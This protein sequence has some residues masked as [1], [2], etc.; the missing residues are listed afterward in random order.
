MLLGLFSCSRE[1]T[2]TYDDDPYL[3]SDEVFKMKLGSDEV[4][5]VR[6]KMTAQEKR[7]YLGYVIRLS[8]NEKVWM[9]TL[10]IEV[11]PGDTI[12]N[13]LIFSEA[14][15]SPEDLVEVQ[16]ENIHVE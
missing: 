9:D 15:V 12:E 2:S 3:V 1:N 14:I 11:S 8:Q 16:T 13:E 4:Y 10:Y 5:G 7:S 6:L